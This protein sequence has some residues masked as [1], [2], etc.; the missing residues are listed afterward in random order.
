MAGT[1]IR[2][3]RNGLVVAVQVVP[4]APRDAIL[5]IAPTA[6]GGAALKVGVTAAPEGGRANAALLRVLADA[7]DVPKS[8]LSVARGAT[9]RRKQIHIEGETRTL[10]PKLQ[11]W[12]ER[13]GG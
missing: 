2:K 10:F 7:W 3:V 13:N 1:P 5:G 11:A 6:D 9:G 12:M 8:A 4:R